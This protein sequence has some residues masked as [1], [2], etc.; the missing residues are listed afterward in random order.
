[1]SHPSLSAAVL[2]KFRNAF[3]DPTTIVNSDTHWTLRR[4]SSAAP[5]HLLVNGGLAQP[6]V[7]IFDSRTPGAFSAV[8]QAETEIDP[9]IHRI[10]QQVAHAVQSRNSH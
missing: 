3:G 8:I 4:P 9:L 5:V 10:R 2:S 7:W 6:I 1:M